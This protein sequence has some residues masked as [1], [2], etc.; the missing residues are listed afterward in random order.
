MRTSLI[1]IKEIEEF[2]MGKSAIESHLLLEAKAQLD[3]QLAENMI[4]QKEAYQQIKH[5]SRKQL[6]M[7]IAAVEQDLF[8]QSRHRSFR[9][10]VLQF[11]KK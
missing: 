11:F 3:P 9:Q 5:Y 8:I 10:K 2:L 7:E 4:L 1:E 6:R